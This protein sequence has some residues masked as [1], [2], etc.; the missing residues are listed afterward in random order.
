MKENRDI[1]L[2]SGSVQGGK[3]SRRGFLKGSALAGLSLGVVGTGL[4]GCAPKQP[5]EDELA[6]T[7][8]GATSAAG[9]QY[10][11]ETVEGEWHH[12]ACSRNCF[13]TCMIMSKVVDGRLVQVCGDK[14]NPYTAGGLCVKTQN[15]V[16]YVYREDR[17][18]YPMKRTGKKGPGCTFERI[19]W[20]EAIQTITDTWKQII[21]ENGGEAITWFRYQG[22]QGAI[23][24]RCLEP[25]FFKMG[26]TYHEA[27]MCNNGYVF[28]LPY[29]TGS[30]TVMRAEDIANKDLYI[31][32][33]HNPAAGSLHT[34]KFI[35][36]MHKAGGKIAVVNPVRV[37]ECEWADLHVQLLPGTDG[38]FA[39]GVAKYLMD[40]GKIDE[41]FI[42]EWSIGYEDY[43]KSAAEWTADKVAAEC[44]IPAEQ[45]GQFAELLW[46]NREN[47][48]LKTGLQ[49]GRRNN[50]GMSHIS[51]KM[52]TGL[53]GHPECYFNMTSSGGYGVNTAANLD[54][55][56][57][58][59]PSESSD[60]STIRNYSSPALGKVLTGVNYGEG[61]DFATNPIRS[62][63]IF[64]GNPMVS[65]PNQNLV[66]EGL[67]REDLFTVVHDIFVTPTVEYAD[68]VLP[69]PTFFEYEEFNGGYGHNY[70]CFNEKVIEPLGECKDNLELCNLLGQAMGY[71]DAVFNRTYDDMR[72]L[73]LDGKDY[74]YD[75]L[76]K[77]GWYDVAPKT[78][79][80]QLEEGFGT[81]SK[82]FQFACD[83]LE[84]DHGTRTVIYTPDPES[85]SQAPELF[86]KYP[87]YLVSPSAKEFLNGVFGNMED[88]N[89]LF[90]E[91]Y[92]FLNEADAQ[93][94]GISDGD[95]VTVFNDRGSLSRKAR[96]VEGVMAP[97]TA[98]TY[99]STW[100]TVT[101]VENVNC[102]TTDSQADFG[103]G[104]AFQSCL[105]EI[106]KA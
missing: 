69:A 43:A 92:V 85:A 81:P 89:L 90:G 57:E 71:D 91:S 52:L 100:S 9:Y 105:V 31:S 56:T 55:F 95:E 7:G 99:K 66:R 103:R 98:C 41:Q 73:F 101:G 59:V 46:E 1:T 12:S 4:V 2:M 10:E 74:T 75:E 47:A 34:M 104:V 54:M 102:V 60:A 14:N 3:V 17:I 37:P 83:E 49:L 13:D 24:R 39:L 78:W 77:N 67:E 20:D 72:A 38:A 80:A 16:D 5:A 35:K 29:T 27:S 94:R 36:E 64:G 23:H 88:N 50:G 48:C 79:E 61:H 32:W 84:A 96:I 82:K 86:A 93:A 26:A 22:N 18:L 45:V 58:T 30:I 19:S 28:S 76:V 33:S 51:I 70:D 25:L 15:Y 11:A 106:A 44:G 42:A 97:G 65:N 53:I 6:D 68:I 62:I 63:M 21:A 8:E 87:L 40:A